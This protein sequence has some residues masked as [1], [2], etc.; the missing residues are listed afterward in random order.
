M[1]RMYYLS[2][3]LDSVE[4]ISESLHQAGV[5]DWNFHVHSKDEAGLTRHHVHSAN[6]IQTMDIVRYGARGMMLGF[7]LSALACGYMIT[8]QPFGTHIDSLAYI[9]IFIFFTLFSTWAGGMIGMM[10]ENQ[11]LAQYHDEI[12][13][14]Q[15]LLLVDVKAG[16]VEEIRQLMASQHPEAKFMREG[17]TLVNPF[18]L[19]Q[20]AH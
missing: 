1:K 13:A 12:E 14:G 5:T 8:A 6:Y 3:S 15:H 9:A 20:P 2:S 16:Q 7:I 4:Q 18:K 11:K 19:A 10:K 17:S